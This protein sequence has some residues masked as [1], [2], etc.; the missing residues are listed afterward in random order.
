M[1]S[2]ELEEARADGS[3]HCGEEAVPGA[4]VLH[5]HGDG[6]QTSLH[7]EREDDVA[8]K[9]SWESHRFFILGSLKY[10]ISLHG[11]LRLLAL[12]EKSFGI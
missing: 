7:R 6:R 5:L 4:R 12:L 9:A 3:D 8:C 1:L 11:L 10:N 2:P